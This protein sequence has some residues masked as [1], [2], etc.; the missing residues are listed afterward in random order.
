MDATTIIAIFVG[1]PILAYH[2]YVAYLVHRA[3]LSW[4]GQSL[5]VVVLT[6]IPLLGA[7]LVHAYIFGSKVQEGQNLGG[8]ASDEKADAE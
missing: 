5:S 2:L 4:G 1:V 3:N 7:L 8:P 6:S